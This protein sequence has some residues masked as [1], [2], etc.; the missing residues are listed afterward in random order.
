MFP[1]AIVLGVL[2]LSTSSRSADQT[3]IAAGSMW[4]YNDSGSN[5]GTAWRTLAY[6]DAGWASGPAQLGYGDGDEATSLSY[7]SDPNNRRI[8]YYFRRSFSVA[9]PA[10]LAALSV[11]FVRDDGVAIYVNG[12]EVVRSNMPSGT[13]SATTLATTAI[14]GADENAWQ[15]ASIDPSVLV[16]GT[17]VLAVELHQQSRSSTDISFD[18]ELIATEAQGPVPTVALTSPSNHGVSNTTSMNFSASV[19]APAG[20]ASASLYVSGPPKTTVFSGPAQI[21]DAQLTADTPT[22]PNG[23]GASL[24]IDGQAPHAHAVMKFPL[25]IGGGGGQVPP[26]AIITSALLQVNCTNAGHS[27]RLYRLTQSWVENQATWNERSA[28]SPWASAG[29]DGAGSNA[30]L[31]LTGVCSATGQRVIDITAFVQEWA[32]GTLNHGMVLTDSG[33]D[34]VDFSSS[35]SA[36]SPVLTVTHKASQQLIGTQA[37][38]GLS[39]QVDFATTLSAGQTYFWNVKVTDTA[40]AQSWA[41]SD[42]DVTVD[43]SAPDEPMLSSPADGATGVVTSP[44]LSA[45]VSDPSGGSL[46][47]RVG[48]RPA[49]Q[50]E[51]TIIVLPDTQHYSEAFPAVF[52]SQTQWIVNNKAARNIVFVTHEGDIVE[53]NNLL[54]E[55][56]AANASMSLLDGVVPYGMGP[57]NHDQPTTLYNQFF[58]YTRYQN[59][60]WYGGHFQNL[61]DNNYQLFSGG[62]IDFVIVHLQFCPPV[63]AVTWA[64]SVLQAHPNRIGI[65]TTHGYLDGAAQR[66]VGGCA[67]TQYLWDGLAVPNPNLHFMLS[68]HV[69]T[70]SRRTDIV[71]GHPV[72][73]M[74]ADY[75]DRPPTGGEGWLR[76]LRFVPSDNKVYVQTYSPWL[77]RFETD[78]DSEFTLD[79]PMGGTFTNAGTVT[80][81]SGS[82]ASITPTAL[83]PFTQYEWQMTVTNAGGKTRTGPVW[84]FTTGAN[85]A[86][87]QPPTAH[88]QAVSTPEDSAASILLSGA[89][90]ENDPLGYSVIS[91]PAHGTLSGSAP[92]LT[93]HPHANYNGADSVTFR[94]NDGQA[95]SNL[96]TVSIAVQPVN[97]APSASGESFS[98]QGGAT[99]AI[100][101]PGV[102]SNDSDIDSATLTAQLTAGATHGS[103]VLNTNGSFSYT[104]SPGY[105]G[106]DSFNYVVRD[107]QADSNVAVVSLTVTVPPP[108]VCSLAPNPASIQQGGAST[109]SWVTANAATLTIDQGIG[110]VSPVASGSRSVSPSS[111]STYAA[112]VTGPGG[113]ANCSATLAVTV[114]APQLVFNSWDV[115]TQDGSPQGVVAAVSGGATATIEFYE[116]A[117]NFGVDRGT[118]LSLF[119]ASNHPDA[120][121]NVTQYWRAA[122]MDY[123]YAGKS[124][125]NRGSDAGESNTPAPTGVRDLQLHPPSNDHTIVA[126]FRVPANGTY[127]I[128]N[129]G[130]RRVYNGFDNVRLRVFNAQKTQLVVLNATSNRAW[131]TTP[132]TFT[133]LNMVAGQYIYFA[134]DRNGDFYYD[135]TEVSWRVTRTAP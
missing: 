134:V 92:A 18:L 106:S 29:A 88:D 10:A 35:E 97:D 85:G 116:S 121:N 68:G 78:A 123:P 17:N 82:T 57:G 112:V 51:F 73:Q 67:S 84:A 27:V 77:N 52:T 41:P 48:L 69:H 12:I 127:V 3:L 40:G 119:N 96:A 55:W 135:A 101:A 100:G 31:A 93:Y 37:V 15:Q 24:N 60:P 7:G 107:G 11:R 56:Q 49:V 59:Q 118:L 86:I 47:V 32:K 129:I 38:A 113:T 90:P 108:P 103:L 16:A 80:A 110:A 114:A 13:I 14:G 74:L 25:L 71:H 58:P 2:V 76:I 54:S 105:S 89:D 50:P 109:L 83:A 22:T 95:N 104:P 34:G 132:A 19:A 46:S 72:Y 53:H 21:E 43:A 1:A 70:E 120:F 64:S 91:G 62:G 20:L 130:V 42:F 44:A 8:T 102:L 131:V 23:Q 133:L 115:L 75:Q 45:L 33:T 124:T 125:V 126:A 30:G 94:I 66:T 6:N 36:N 5:L 65:M 99:L 28:G 111:T 117:N 9:N 39:A 128:S 98:I 81:V 26:G 61:N 122:A 4:K 87:N 79:F 63:A